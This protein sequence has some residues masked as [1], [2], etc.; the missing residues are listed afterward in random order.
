MEIRVDHGDWRLAIGKNNE[1]SLRV[2]VLYKDFL[3]F[4]MI[5]IIE[6][7]IRVTNN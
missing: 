3:I 4:N 5:I 6:L 7:V 2:F 1:Q